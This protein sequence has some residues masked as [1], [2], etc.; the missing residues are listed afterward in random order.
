M[1]LTPSGTIDSLSFQ[2]GSGLSVRV[3]CREKGGSQ[4]MF[5]EDVCGRMVVSFQ[6]PFFGKAFSDLSGA[7]VGVMELVLDYLVL[8]FP[9]KPFGM[10][11]VSMRLICKALDIPAAFSIPFEV[12]VYGTDWNIC[13]FANL[14]GCFLM[15]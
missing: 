15:L 2:A 13:L 3:I 5:L 4:T 6:N 11:L 8:V 9:L 14:L 10:R 1:S 7:Q 12:T